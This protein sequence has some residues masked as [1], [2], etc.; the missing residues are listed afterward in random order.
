METKN[1]FWICIFGLFSLQSNAKD[2]FHSQKLVIEKAYCIIHYTLI[3]NHVRRD[4]KL[5]V[6]FTLTLT[7]ENKTILYFLILMHY[8][9]PKACFV[10]F[11]LI[12]SITFVMQTLPAMGS[13]L[14]IFFGC[15]LITTGVGKMKNSRTDIL[16]KLLCIKFIVK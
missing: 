11:K 13:C 12:F 16:G 15:I 10:S 8:F 1:G 5:E 2:C 14:I 6:M 7:S 3:T 4:H 9:L